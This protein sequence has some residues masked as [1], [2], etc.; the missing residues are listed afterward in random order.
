M[1]RAHGR[2]AAAGG[3]RLPAPGS[4]KGLAWAPPSG[5]PPGCPRT[6]GVCGPLL[7][8]QLRAAT[9]LPTRRHGRAAQCRRRRRRRGAEPPTVCCPVA[10]PAD[11]RALA[12][13]KRGLP[14]RG[15]LL[16][17]GGCR[18]RRHL[19]GNWDHGDSITS[20][21]GRKTRV[22]DA[23]PGCHHRRRRRRHARSHQ[24]RTD[25]RRR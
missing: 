10:E 21:F 22:P 6:S 5:A 3:R 8:H 9:S 23:R 19:L 12:D 24:Q 13:P 25:G 17:R 20:R 16:S 2:G 11:A 1:A 18:N 15:W 7:R 4:A 14:T